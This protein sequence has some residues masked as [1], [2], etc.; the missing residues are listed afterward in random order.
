MGFLGVI[1]N[2]RFIGGPKS[3]VGAPSSNFFNFHADFE[4]IVAK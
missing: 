4:K 2:N 1:M 3:Q